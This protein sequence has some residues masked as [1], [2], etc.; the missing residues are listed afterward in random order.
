MKS[1]AAF[2]IFL[3][4]APAFGALSVDIQ[5]D[6][7][8]VITLTDS[9]AVDVGSYVGTTLTQRSLRATHP[10]LRNYFV[11]FRPDANGQRQ[12]V[13]F[14][15]GG[16]LASQVDGGAAAVVTMPA[17]TVTIRHDG[18]VVAT[19]R[20]TTQVGG[21]TVE[22]HGWNQRWRWQ[23]APRPIVK[24]KQQLTDMMLLLPYD[25]SLDVADQ[26]HAK[27]VNQTAL[28]PGDMASE[29][30]FDR[31]MGNVAE[32]PDIGPITAWLA[33][34]L[35]GTSINETTIRA[36]ADVAAGT[37]PWIWRDRAGSGAPLYVYDYPNISAH[38]AD[39]VDVANY[40]TQVGST[41]NSTKSYGWML[42]TAHQPA[43]LAVPYALTEDPYY[44]E[45]VQF[46]LSW[47]YA[48]TRRFRWTEVDG[49]TYGPWQDAQLR[50]H[51][52]SLRTLT[53]AWLL[54]PAVVPSWLNSKADYLQ[55]L[56]DTAAVF[57]K[58]TIDM[59]D[60][61]QLWQHAFRASGN[62]GSFWQQP[63]MTVFAARNAAL[64]LTGWQALA[65]WYFEFVYAASGGESGWDR[66][67]PA[68]YKRFMGEAE[69]N[70]HG[71]LAA[72]I[73]ATNWADFYA[74]QGLPA[75]VDENIQVDPTS[76]FPRRDWYYYSMVASAHA[77]MLRIGVTKN[78]G[79][80]TAYDWLRS[81][82]ALLG[83]VPRKW[84]VGKP[85]PPATPTPS[86]TPTRT[87]TATATATATRTPTKTATNT[88]TNTPTNTATSTPTNT[89]TVTPTP[90]LPCHLVTTTS[91][92]SVTVRMECP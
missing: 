89:P 3:A 90:T 71:N 46:Q 26:E 48:W 81:Q 21:A 66:R 29:K 10:T 79:V 15:Y 50:G 14:E 91:G 33:S 67:Y 35:A 13:V 92:P 73:A 74:A 49:V 12:E 59:A 1:I 57:D 45:G 69:T 5:L 82:A 68:Q 58:R 4:C 17:H 86:A 83:F 51:S 40:V 52:Y 62:D 18:A 54:T 25:W 43:A 2:V 53:D 84:A 28:A 75:P 65:E 24:T 64:G 20:P 76:G 85:G 38:N 60:P 41:V 77:M 56:N 7:Q 32:R 80:V 8:P 31:S 19:V 23:S 44:L 9:A 34:Y 47:I 36:Q 61:Q 78:G 63:M 6:G 42:D 72:Q 30:G 55:L 27:F 39:A 70:N 22:G 11:Y 88:P 37:M 87:P 16:L